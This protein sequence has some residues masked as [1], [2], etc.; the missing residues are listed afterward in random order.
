MRQGFSKSGGNFMAGCNIES[1]GRGQADDVKAVLDYVTAQPWADKHN[2][3]MLGQ[4]YGGWTTLAFG[5]H[6]YPGVKALVNFA[7]GLRQPACSA[8]EGG[9]V[10]GA[11]KYA[12]ET[13]L[14]SLWFYG[15]NDSYFSTATFNAMFDH[16][17][18]AGG[19][20][21]LV[22]FGK[23]GTDAHSMFSSRAGAPIW[24]PEVTKLLASVG[25]PSEPVPAYASMGMAGLV[26]MPV[27]TTFAMLEDDS[28]LP[29]VK[30][31]GRHGYKAYLSKVVPR[32]FAIGADG[33][34]SWAEEGEDPIKRAL[35][36]C[37]RQS[38]AECRLYSVDDAVV[39]AEMM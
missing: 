33:A 32:A 20:A 24:Q 19:R 38:K 5:P 6:H 37:K 7:G 29:Y 23:F 39:W 1:N 14:P 18:A 12:R 4:S 30:E 13:S 21:R 8:W 34:W 36:S 35:D 27:K 16:Y 10:Q 15:D 25:L 3:V 22:A 28:R 11:A 26:P 9:L 17:T 31:S 2:M